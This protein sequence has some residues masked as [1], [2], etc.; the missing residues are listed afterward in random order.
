MR[1]IIACILAIIYFSFTAAAAIS[2]PCC[3]DSHSISR[4]SFKNDKGDISKDL[5][6]CLEGCKL[7]KVHKQFTA[8]RVFKTPRLTFFAPAVTVYTSPYNGHFYKPGDKI[9]SPSS[10][11]N[12]FIKNCVL[13]IWY[14]LQN[15]SVT[16]TIIVRFLLKVTTFLF[17][18][19]I[20]QTKVFQTI[21]NYAKK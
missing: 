5:P 20:T 3:S 18:I 4:S 7:Y 14:F 16:T 11:V 6:V 8:L 15:T 17:K 12:I 21:F 2:E 19:L 1:R 13:R 9:S 10:P